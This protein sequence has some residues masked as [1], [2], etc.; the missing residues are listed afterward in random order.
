MSYNDDNRK[1]SIRTGGEFNWKRFSMNGE[2]FCIK[3]M[4]NLIYWKMFIIF[5]NFYYKAQFV[6]NN[7]K[8]NIKFYKKK[9]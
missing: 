9:N 1:L 5:M 2:V 8:I 6:I 3:L 7:M 4:K